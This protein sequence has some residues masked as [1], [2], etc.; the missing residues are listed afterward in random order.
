VTN[1]GRTIVQNAYKYDNNGNVIKE[2]TGLGRQA[3]WS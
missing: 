3:L 2:L 1:P